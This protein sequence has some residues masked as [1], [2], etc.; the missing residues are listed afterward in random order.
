[1]FESITCILLTSPS[2]YVH[3]YEYVQRALLKHI[4]RKKPNPI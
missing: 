4:E 1:M 3:T 2:K